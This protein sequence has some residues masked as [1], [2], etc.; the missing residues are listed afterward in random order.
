MQ[1]SHIEVSQRRRPSL[2]QRLLTLLFGLY[3]LFLLAYVIMR[4]IFGDQLWWLNMLHNGAPF[5]FL[6]LVIILP[7][8]LL[9]RAK[10]LAGVALLLAI[11][12]G[13]WLVPRFLPAA[14]PDAP[15]GTEF[16]LISF[17]VY[18]YNETMEDVIDWL[19]VQDAD[20]VLLQEVN[21]DYVPVVQEAMADRYPVQEV[22]DSVHWDMLLSRYDL[23][24]HE[25]ID[26]QGYN[27]QRFVLDIDG[28]QVEIYSVHLLMPVQEEPRFA[29]EPPPELVWRYNETQRDAQITQLLQQ[30]AQ[31]DLPVIVAGDFNTNEFSP[32]YDVIHA[33]MLDAFRRTN[34]GLG[35]TW[36]AGESEEL[37][38]VLPPLLR[39]DYVWSTPQIVPLSS[40]IGP[41]F[42]SDHLPLSVT[43]KIIEE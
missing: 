13:I 20:I 12:G 21:V 19:R 3:L 25:I 27:H 1:S 10:R 30:V 14:P 40:T 33:N 31:S 4:P 17:N 43:L 26:L 38:D 34:W 7:L 32:I 41:K 23:I 9:M 35:A 36:P 37:P 5:Y 24:E 28:Q 42:G 6:P 15:Y 22:N 11:V 16:D 29:V 2:L 18:P 39:L 8:A